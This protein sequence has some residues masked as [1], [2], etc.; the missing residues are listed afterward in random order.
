MT[1]NKTLT[2]DEI[3]GNAHCTCYH[4]SGCDFDYTKLDQQFLQWVADEVVGIDELEVSPDGSKQY[5]GRMSRNSLRRKQR[6]ILKDH[7]W[8]G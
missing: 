8:K 5:Q 4:E 6:Q 7:G 1:K 3:I 2:L